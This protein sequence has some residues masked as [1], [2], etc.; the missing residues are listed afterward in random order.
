MSI[1]ID[2]DEICIETRT[3]DPT[4]V[5]DSLPVDDTMTDK[6]HIISLTKT[7]DN[8]IA[9]NIVVGDIDDRSSDS[10]DDD[11]TRDGMCY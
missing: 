5:L 11:G 9:S 4:V 7:E 3:D 8:N 2:E 1:V 10:G 6:D